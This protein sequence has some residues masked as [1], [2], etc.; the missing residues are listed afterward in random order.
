MAERSFAREVEDLKLGDGEV[1]R[2]EGI[3]A[4][5]KALLQSRRRLCRRLPGRADLASDGR[6]RRRARTSWTS[7]ACISRRRASE[8]TA[9]ATL[10]GLG[11][12]SDPRR[13]DLEVDRRHQ[14][15]LRRALQPRL[16]RRHRRRADHRRRGL[17]RGLLDHAGAQPR[18]RDEVAD[19]AARS[20]AQ[21]AS[22]SCKAV[23]DGLRA[24][25]GLEHAGDARGPHPRLPRARPLRRQGQPQPRLHAR[26]RRWRIP[27]RDINRIV[28]PPASFLH[29]KEKI[30][31]RWPAAIEF[32]RERKLNETF[33]PATGEVG[34]VLQGGMYN[35]VMRALQ[36][37]GLADVYGNTRVPLYVLNVTYPADRR[38]GRRLLPSTR[39]RC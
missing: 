8:A 34:I 27:V 26:A 10:V 25:G 21:P 23:E 28:L 12:V 13:G 37:L 38:R 32:I 17:W 15:R 36:Q 16:G 19:L 9:A 7:S 20:A 3:L 5:T 30:E 18:L 4:I 1:F 14:R 35:G 39:T 24:V 6:A 2:G 31:K 22:R 29:E 11:H 33:G